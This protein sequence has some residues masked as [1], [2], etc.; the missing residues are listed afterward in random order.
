[1]LAGYDNTV[2]F[3]NRRMPTITIIKRDAI[4]G[5]Y[6]NGAEFHNELPRP[7]GRGIGS[8][9]WLQVKQANL[10]IFGFFDFV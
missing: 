3:Q 5:E 2:L 4:T 9:P 1:M 6:I 10:P 7:K 8:R